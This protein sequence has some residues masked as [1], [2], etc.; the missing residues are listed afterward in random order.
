[1]EWLGKIPAHWEA[2]RLRFACVVN[3][4]KAELSNLPV[5]TEV[6]FLPMD[7][8]SEDG[9]LDLGQTRRLDQ[10]WQGYTNF[11]DGD[12]IVAKITPCFENGKGALCGDLLEGVGFGTTELE[13]L[14]PHQNMYSPFI[15]YLTKSHPFR[16]LGIASMKGV[17]GQQRITEDFVKD[18]TVSIPPY[19]EQQTIA[20]FLHRETV[21]IDALVAKKERLIELLQEKRA[22]LITRAVTKGLEPTVPMKDS[23]VEWLGQVPAHWEVKRLFHLTDPAVPIVYGILLPG[24]RLEEGVP[25]IGAGDVATD[26]L[27]IDSLPRTTKETASQYPRSRMCSGE[28]VY[29]IRGSFGAV[30]VLPPELDGVNLSRDAARIAPGSTILGGWL[31]W[32]LRSDTSQKQFELNELGATITGVNIR[33]LKRIL[34]PCPSSEEQAYITTFLDHE[35][36]KLDALITKVRE[37]IEKLKEYRT[38]LISAAVT[39]KIDVREAV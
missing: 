37:G 21:K 18:F 35:T 25:Y 27:R 39:G 34:L 11:R 15:F 5:S 10:V 12:V 19:P 4:G 23:G 6:S 2:K 29:A 1:M 9:T 20:V 14:R 22:A 3:P 28:L 33:D 36:A 16:N 13:V 24:P 8:I 7:A 38:A 17:A 31:C 32:A 26:R 30:E